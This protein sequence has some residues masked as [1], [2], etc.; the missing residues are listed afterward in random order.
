MHNNGITIPKTADGNN[1]TAPLLNP[2]SLVGDGKR[3]TK[4]VLPPSPLIKTRNRFQIERL[5]S[6]SQATYDRPS[7]TNSPAIKRHETDPTMTPTNRK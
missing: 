4:I 5:Q 7:V 6:D 1:H 2:V 3:T